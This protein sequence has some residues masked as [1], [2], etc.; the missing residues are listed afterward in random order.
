VE[1]GVGVEADGWGKIVRLVFSLAS[2]VLGW[3][4]WYF[5]CAANK[6]AIGAQRSR[7]LVEANVARPHARLGTHSMILSIVFWIPVQAAGLLD[8]CSLPNHQICFSLLLSSSSPSPA[9]ARV[10]LLVSVTQMR[11]LR[12]SRVDLIS[13]PWPKEI[14]P[15]ASYRDAWRR[16]CTIFESQV[17]SAGA[18]GGAG[19]TYR[20]RLAG[21][22]TRH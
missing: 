15:C 9:A 3:A 5:L 6:T 7:A 20:N 14:G 18:L 21:V 17:S 8:L 11:I 4:G 13:V 16:G 12:G 1:V 22:T 10:F 19:T 2:E